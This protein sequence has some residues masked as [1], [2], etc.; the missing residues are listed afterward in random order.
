MPK[1]IDVET[2][3]LEKALRLLSLPRGIGKH[4]ETGS[5]IEAGLGRFGPYLLHDGKYTRLDSVEEVFTVG[6]N[7]AVTII[8]EKAAGGGKGR[9]GAAK[10][11]VLKD[12]GE[13]P[14]GGKIEVLAGK[15]GPY[16]K[17]GKINATIPKDK[18]PTEL[19][20]DEAVTL[21]AERAGKAGAK[22]GPKSGAKAGRRTAQNGGSAGASSAE[23][24]TR[25]DTKS[26]KAP[27]GKATSKATGPKSTPKPGTK[28]AARKPT[29]S[30]A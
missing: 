11:E 6:I 17:Y 28:R 7:R 10:A 5:D 9:F 1:G 27:A 24:K 2:L 14:Q 26:K 20:L 18:Q 13:H 21:I 15:Y 12:L 23:P 3:D 16:V 29:P 4:P 22:G 25:A 19:T 8:A 30:E